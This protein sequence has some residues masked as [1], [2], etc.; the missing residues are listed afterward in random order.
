MVQVKAR[1]KKG[2]Y[3]IGAFCGIIGIGALFV[4]VST[5]ILY[6]CIGAIDCG[7]PE[8]ASRINPT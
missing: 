3:V 8:Y 5:G 4:S 7:M 6:L 1:A 2:M